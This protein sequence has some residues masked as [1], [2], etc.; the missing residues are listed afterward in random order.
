MVEGQTESGE[1]IEY[2]NDEFTYPHPFYDGSGLKLVIEL[3]ADTE[4]YIEDGKHTLYVP[5]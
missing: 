5:Y 1:V 3:R 2:A 4:V